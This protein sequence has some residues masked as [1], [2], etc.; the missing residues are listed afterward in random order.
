MKRIQNNLTVNKVIDNE[1]SITFDTLKAEVEKDI[2][3]LVETRKPHQTTDWRLKFYSKKSLLKG[4]KKC[5]ALVG[6][7]VEQELKYCGKN[8]FAYKQITKIKHHLGLV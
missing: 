7:A 5:E 4:I 6:R 3:L 2:Q 1:L 8:T